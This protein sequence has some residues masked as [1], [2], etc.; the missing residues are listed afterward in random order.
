MFALIKKLKL[1]I[2]YD[3]HLG[4]YK[5]KS[6]VNNKQSSSKLFGI[7]KQLSSGVGT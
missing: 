2:K 4:I 5:F 3:K 6:V 7:R 1:R